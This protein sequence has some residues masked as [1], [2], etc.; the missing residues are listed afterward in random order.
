MDYILQI[1]DLLITKGVDIFL[2][3]IKALL[4]LFI[5]LKIVRLLSNAFG[6]IMIRRGVDISLQTFLKSVVHNT[7]RI[8]LIISV[9]N[10]LGIEMTSFF[11][12]LGAAGLAIG[13]ALQGSLSNFA[14]GVLILLLKPFKVGDSI[15]AQGVSGTVSDIQLFHTVLKTFDFKTIIIPN[16]PLYNA[17]IINNTTEP[18][19]KVEWNLNISYNEDIDKVRKI[20]S[21]VVFN[22]ERIIDRTNPYIQLSS[23][24]DNTVKIQV[25]GLVKNED[26]SNVFA[27]KLEAIKKAFSQENI[28]LPNPDKK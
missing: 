26:H 27:E 21:D 11:A 17:I 1:K 13:M 2:I 7:L 4:V 20:I 22:D 10:T 9:L 19:R 28:Q 12:I 24:V 16:G 14:G 23:L 5:G 25:R 18:Q 6:Q 8:L 15:E 3:L